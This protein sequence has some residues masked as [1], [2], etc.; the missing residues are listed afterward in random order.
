[1]YYALSLYLHS[2]GFVMNGEQVGT[3][4]HVTIFY[5]SS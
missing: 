5:E 2:K 3:L 4:S 1:M